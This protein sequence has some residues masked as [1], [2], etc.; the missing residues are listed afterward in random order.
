M[1][2]L[3]VASLILAG[4]FSVNSCA[5]QGTPSGGPKDETPPVLVGSNPDT[6]SVNVD[7]NIKEIEIH[8][9][10]YIQLKD[11]KT[12]AVVSPPFERN[13]IISP[14]SNADK[15]VKIKLQEPL[16]ENTTYSFNFGD[17]IQDFN[18]NN[19]LSNFTYVFSTGSYIDS[20]NVKGKVF[21]GYDFELPKK[22]LVGLY[23]ADSTFND[24]VILKSKPYY[25]S[26][27]DEKGEYNLK[28]LRPG[29]YKIVA[30]QDEIENNKFDLGREKIA[31]QNELINLEGNQE[32]DLKLFKPKP[33]YRLLSSEQ[34]GYGQLLFKTEGATEPLE[35]KPI[36]REFSTALVDVHL[37]NDSVN[38]WFNPAKEEFKNR[39]ERLKFEVKH[40]NNVDTVTVLYTQPTNE[41]ESSFK[42]INES[43][44]APTSNFKIAASAPIK[45]IDKSLIYA[46]KDT[47]QIPFEVEIDSIDKQVVHF[48]FEKNLG[49]KFEINAFPKAIIDQF[50]VPNDT[51]VYQINTG[52]REDFGNLKLKINNL[53]DSPIILQLIKKNQ[54]F[55][56]IEEV[57]GIMRDFYFP[58]LIPGDYY[59]RLLVD[60]NRNGIWDT[61]DLMNQTQPEPSY[62]YPS[63]IL[64]RAMWDTDETWIIGADS[65]KF[66]LQKEVK[67]EEEKQSNKRL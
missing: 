42:A 21:S 17:A 49:E 2:K 20:L 60:K 40:G 26:R 65:D 19:K 8:F 5:R 11:Y 58:N 9:D 27:V 25:I 47:V 34:K 63:K 55:D 38:F 37:A 10:E 22:V 53:D 13:P 59:F 46:F 62:I 52:S 32:I 51:L 24:S 36:E 45:S 14:L 48:K 66:I 33:T 61:G 44:L 56:V 3:V 43:K 4:I 35:I 50:D 30:F 7:P 23:E 31:F 64:I 28:Y 1:K 29:N 16:L 39:A 54:K 6:L 18:E 57:K 15:V 41:Y 67:P 12:N